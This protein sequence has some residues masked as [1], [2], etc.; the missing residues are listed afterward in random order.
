MNS[1]R[2]AVVGA[3]GAVGQRP[4]S[5]SG[6]SGD[7]GA[8]AGALIKSATRVSGSWGSG[9]LIKTSLVSLL[10]TDNGR[11]LVGAVTPQVLYSAAAQ[12]TK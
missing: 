2:I 11:V 10:I 3:T 8:V 6:L 4:S 9:R 5:G 7:T 12:V 1:Y